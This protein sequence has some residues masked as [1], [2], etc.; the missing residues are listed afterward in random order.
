MLNL[1]LN[2]IAAGTA[3]S[4]YNGLEKYILQVLQI[5]IENYFILRFIAIILVILMAFMYFKNKYN[6]EILKNIKGNKYIVLSL[7]FITGFMVVLSDFLTILGLKK[8]SISRF[9]FITTMT[10]LMINIIIGMVFF[11]ERYNHKQIIGFILAF[12]AI[13]LIND[14]K[15]LY[16]KLIPNKYYYY[17]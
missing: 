14:E 1:L 16:N 10:I 9:M 15:I 5:K 3:Y 7:I 11:N 13:I 17:R 12:I 8:F 6:P 2:G 4:I